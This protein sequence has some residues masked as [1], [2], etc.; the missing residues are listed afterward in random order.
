[1]TIRMLRNIN[2]NITTK[3]DQPVNMRLM[4]DKPGKRRI[5]SDISGCCPCAVV[6]ELSQ[7]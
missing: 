6:N 5:G 3:L 1:M 7:F 2:T 4:Q